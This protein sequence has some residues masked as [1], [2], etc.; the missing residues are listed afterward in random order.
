[1]LL[2]TPDILSV[3]SGQPW[4]LGNVQQRFYYRVNYNDRTWDGLV[5]QMK[6]NHAVRYFSSIQIVSIVKF[7][8]CVKIL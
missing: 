8:K 3:P 7:R 1:M 6:S 5:T 2:S 4:I